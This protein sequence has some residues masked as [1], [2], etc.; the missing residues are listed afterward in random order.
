[1]VFH[2]LTRGY[3]E[4]GFVP[5]CKTVNEFGE[6]PQYKN[7]ANKFSPEPISSVQIQ[8]RPQRVKL[9]NTRD[10]LFFH[11]LPRHGTHKPTTQKLPPATRPARSRKPVRGRGKLWAGP[12]ESLLAVHWLPRRKLR[13]HPAA[14][15]PFHVLG[16]TASSAGAGCHHAPAVC[17]LGADAHPGRPRLSPLRFVLTER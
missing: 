11:Q 3:K 10:A 2:M 8:N 13:Y 6:I 1:M 17:S 7:L 4:A 14:H 12:Q 16:N 5:C 15:A 9:H